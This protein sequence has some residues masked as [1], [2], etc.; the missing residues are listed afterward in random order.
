MFLK[1]DSRNES[2]VLRHRYGNDLKEMD[3]YLRT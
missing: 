3:K 1:K 2:Y